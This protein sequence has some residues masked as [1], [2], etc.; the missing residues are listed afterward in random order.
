MTFGETLA[1]SAEVISRA[2]ALA[3]GHIAGY[4]QPD[5]PIATADERADKADIF[6]VTR[7]RRRSLLR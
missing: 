7:F 3:H 1:V 4:A 5:F 2:L 6:D